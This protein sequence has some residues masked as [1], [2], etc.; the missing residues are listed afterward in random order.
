MEIE[1][2]YMNIAKAIN[3]VITED[4][5]NAELEI[6]AYLNSYVEFE[7]SYINVFNEK[8][9][10][11]V[12]KFSGMN[13]PDSIYFLQKSME[14]NTKWNRAKFNITSDGTFDMKFEW[15]E[16][17]DNERNSNLKKYKKGS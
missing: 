15:D 8:K 13:L 1:D 17:R 10:I 9:F 5:K 2:V 11:D 6:E 3:S 16:E 12:R 14:N 7:G 4:W